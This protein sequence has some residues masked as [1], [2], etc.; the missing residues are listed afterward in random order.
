MI[1]LIFNLFLY[2][3]SA[4]TQGKNNS[5]ES[6]KLKI[7]NNKVKVSIEQQKNKIIELEALVGQL[8]SR[9]E[10]QEN[11]LNTKEGKEKYFTLITGPGGSTHGRLGDPLSIRAFGRNVADN[12]KLIDSFYTKKDMELS[13]IIQ[14]AQREDPKKAFPGL[15][16]KS[17]ALVKDLLFIADDNVKLK[18]LAKKTITFKLFPN[19]SC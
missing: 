1:I 3:C 15:S 13:D 2:N 11:M 9:I 12:K 10:Y 18:N 6:N 16:K 4:S 7:E 8:N 19:I 17:D 14:Q 5:I